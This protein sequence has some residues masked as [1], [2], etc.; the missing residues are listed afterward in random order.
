VNPYRN[1]AV[2]LGTNN[3]V[4]AWTDSSQ[5]QKRGN[6]GMADGSVEDLSISHLRS[7]AS[8]AGASYRYAGP[9]ILPTGVNRLIFPGCPDTPST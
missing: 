9:G 2:A 1:K 4:A 5:H 7:A 6:V 8:R 3:V